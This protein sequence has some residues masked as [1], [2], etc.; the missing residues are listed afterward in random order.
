[1]GVTRSSLGGAIKINEKAESW[2]MNNLGIN[3]N[4]LPASDPAS[5]GRE[6]KGFTR[7]NSMQQI[8]S[9][10]GVFNDERMSQ[11]SS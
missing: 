7:S 3:L 5:L 1:M 11:A 2:L 6:Q 10:S 4:E 9:K 8:I